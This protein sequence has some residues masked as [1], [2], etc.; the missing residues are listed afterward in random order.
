MLPS[1]LPLVS[2]QVS[3]VEVNL[4]SIHCI[5]EWPSLYHHFTNFDISMKYDDVANLIISDLIFSNIG[6]IFSFHLYA[7]HYTK[8]IYL[9]I[10]YQIKTN[11]KSYNTTQQTK[12]LLFVTLSYSI[13]YIDDRQRL[14]QNTAVLICVELLITRTFKPF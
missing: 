5:H 6:L 10:V 7:L 9:Y 13:F 11:L 14:Q 12:D 2:W 8:V 3:S 1:V 4:L